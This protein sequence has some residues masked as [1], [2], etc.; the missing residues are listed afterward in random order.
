MRKT[1]ITILVAAM[2]LTT[3]I[4]TTAMAAGRGRNCPYNYVD[5]DGDGYCD[6]YGC[7]WGNGQ[8]RCNGGRWN[9]QGMGCQFAD[10]DGDGICDYYTDEN[11]NGICDRRENIVVDETDVIGVPQSIN[12][13]KGK[14]KIL[15]FGTGKNTYYSSNSRV[16]KVNQEG[17]ITAKAKGNAIITIKNG[18]KIMKCKVI[19][20]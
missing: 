13:Q 11:G 17:K 2:V 16:A 20:K 4:P 6:Y 8:G 3:S 12:L 19:V 15:K 10:I 7:G 1:A 5:A 14:S 18:A 9:G